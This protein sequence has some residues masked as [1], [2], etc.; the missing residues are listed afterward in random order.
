MSDQ[1]SVKDILN[2]IGRELDGD[3][4]EGELSVRDM[5]FKARLL[6][7]EESN[8]RYAHV[9]PSNTV[10]A[11]SSYK[12]PTLAIGIREVYHKDLGGWVSVFEFFDEDWQKLPE[13]TRTSLLE[14]NKFSKKYFVAEHFMEWLSQRREM[15]GELYNQWEQLE[16]RRKESQEALK[17]SSGEDSEMEKSESSTESS[18]DGED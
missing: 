11:V 2:D 16:Q 3:N 12:L 7:E 14:M 15:V 10:S 6:T 13:L 4:L 18:P 17:K 9:D 8:W 5:K 1:R